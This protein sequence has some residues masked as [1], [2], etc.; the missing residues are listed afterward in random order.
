VLSIGKVGGG[1]GDPRYYIDSVAKGRDDYY[2]GH[3]EAQGEWH[4]SGA[5]AQ[6]LSGPVE[7]DA[8]LGILT[9]PTVRT[10]KVLAYDLTFSAP[11]SVSVIYGIGDRTVSPV[12]REAHDE[13]VREALGYLER[14]A[15]WTRRG[16]AGKDR[17]QGDGLTVA[18][19]RHRTSRAGDPQLHTHAV[20]ANSTVADG[21]ASALDGRALYAHAR[22]AGFLYQAVLRK[23][24]T[25]HLG[26]EWEPV[27]NG[28]AEV[29]GIDDDVLRHFSRRSQE[30]RERMRQTGG[31]SARSAEIAALETRRSKEYN[32]PANRL[33]EEWRA[34]AS[35][36]GLGQD[37]LAAILDRRAP[38][39]ALEPDLAATAEEL[40]APGGVT[41]EASTFDRRD[42]LCDWAEA[43]REGAGVDR[44][45]ALADRWLSSNHAVQLEGDDARRHLGG[46]RHSTPDMLQLEHRLI[47]EAAVRRASGVATSDTQAVDDALAARPRMSAEQAAMVR[48]L[49]T[50][51]DGVQVVRAA[52]GTG[53]TY[54]LEVA[55]H[56]WEAESTRVFGCSLAA[57]AAVELETL[58]GIDST[59]IA[60]LLRDIDRGDGL[61]RGSVLV[62]DEAG[63]VGSRTI[64]RL[65]DHAAETHSKLVLLGDDHQLPEI[66]AGGAFRK[67]ADELGAVELHDVH[68]Q[69]AP[70]DREALDELRRGKV[71]RW[72][73]SY[74]DH[75][76]L[77]SRSTSDALRETL[78]DD[79]WEAARTANDDAVMIAHRRVDVAELNALARERMH[80]D[81]RLGDEE[82]VASNRAFS[83][84]DRV[85][86][87]RNDRRAHV[88]NGMRGDLVG[89]DLDQRT[90]TV[91]T[92]SGETR[93]VRRTSTT[94]G[95]TMG[96]P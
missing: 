84:G 73:E 37:E 22:T 80:R 75:G 70:W 31:R 6:G 78:V 92:Q 35:E 69:S 17:V 76:R 24:L 21:Y 33:R 19:F 29:S 72:T 86:A 9:E 3:G 27:H 51:G 66:D 81:G 53:K 11:K 90:A 57:R 63:M 46:A 13:A 52:A 34:S 40:A 79:W 10:K 39:R 44:L 54:A 30:I 58:A 18:A 82:L 64:A 56:T 20:V 60:R 38:S 71:R 89:V 87:R 67:L 88:I 1:Q 36:L 61:P 59:T 2:T 25:E 8:F 26:V 43:H 95:S 77:V 15:C 47:T 41:R 45:E 28:V 4:G 93:E 55:R 96:T 12:A 62:V 48:S 49:T 74:R 65:A 91:R 42:V 68:R 32:V 14:H 16:P 83:I 85:V 23:N 7:D 50:S 94:G 5:K